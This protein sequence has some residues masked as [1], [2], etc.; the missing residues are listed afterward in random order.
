ME[1]NHS[2]T[3]QV[4]IETRVKIRVCDGLRLETQ[5]EEKEEKELSS[6]MGPGGTEATQP[7]DTQR[8]GFSSPQP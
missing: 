2:Q 3:T 5:T 6:C 4:F 1:L 8:Q 7:S